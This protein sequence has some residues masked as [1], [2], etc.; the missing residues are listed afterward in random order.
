MKRSEGLVGSY[1][2]PL[3]FPCEISCS[4]DRWPRHRGRWDEYR[5]SLPAALVEVAEFESSAEALRVAVVVAMPGLLQ[6]RDHARASFAQSVPPLRADLLEQRVSFRIKRQAV[7]Y[8]ERPVRYTAIIHEAALR[9][10]FGGPEVVGSSCAT[11]LRRGSRT[12]SGS[13]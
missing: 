10:S 2:R 5:E 11:S 9:M 12:T 7:L 4:H 6:T 8:G 3:P 1:A 13:W